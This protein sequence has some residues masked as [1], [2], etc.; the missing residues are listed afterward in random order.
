MERSF[1]GDSIHARRPVGPSEEHGSILRRDGEGGARRL[2]HIQFDSMVADR[3]WFGLA[4]RKDQVS[5]V[6]IKRGFAIIVLK[7]LALTTLGCGRFVS[8]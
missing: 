1:A 6:R 5:L 2:L 8:Y 4:C 7:A 3:L